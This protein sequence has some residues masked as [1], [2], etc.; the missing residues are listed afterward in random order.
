MPKEITTDQDKLFASK[1]WKSLMNQLE[2][3]H[4]LSTAFHP[5]TDSQTERLNQTMEQYLRC[6]VNYKQD[7]WIRLLP[8]AIIAYNS[9][10]NEALKTSPF[11]MNYRYNAMLT[12]NVLNQHPLAENAQLTANELKELHSELQLDVQ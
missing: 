2:S 1:F 10:E 3:K 5:Q 11:F 4:K 12:H 7:N 8:L 9:S 6:Y